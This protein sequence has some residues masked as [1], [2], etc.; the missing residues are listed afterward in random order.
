MS[1]N[2]ST[3][4]PTADA[5]TTRTAAENALWQALATR[6]DS[7][8]NTLAVAA[9]IGKSTAQ[10]ILARWGADG[11]VV[12]TSGEAD[13][14]RCAADRWSIPD[15]ASTVDNQPETPDD[16]DQTAAAPTSDRS[17]DDQPAPADGATTDYAGKRDR[18]APGALRGLV[19]DFLRD[20]T[21][22]FSPNTIGKALNRSSG[23]VHN[24]LEKLV[25]SGYATR[26]SDK[27]KKYAIATDPTGN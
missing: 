11:V 23:A 10:K 1:T 22:E 16:D 25:A 24:A 27:P 18:L 14:G 4:E 5:P 26:T 8:T 15:D 2:T 17:V 7:T 13:G 21:G 6:G 12:R 3:C 19:E 20:N 9:E